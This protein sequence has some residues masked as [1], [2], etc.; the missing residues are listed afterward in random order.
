MTPAQDP[1]CGALAKITGALLD[2]LSAAPGFPAAALLEA[3]QVARTVVVTS[4]TRTSTGAREHD[5]LLAGLHLDLAAV[6]IADASG[7]G[8]PDP[9][10]DHHGERFDVAAKPAGRLLVDRCARVVQERLDRGS[11]GAAAGGLGAE[12]LLACTRAVLHLDAARRA[13]PEA[14]T[15]GRAS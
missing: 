8:A 6:E 11:G 15:P 1:P 14:V 9:F 12:Q 7:L 3:L 5:G 4:P 10:G 2:R 13:W